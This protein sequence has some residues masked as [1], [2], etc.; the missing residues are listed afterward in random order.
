MVDMPTDRSPLGAFLRSRRDRLTPAQAGIT[1]FPGPRRVPGLR[2]EELAIL[3]GIIVLV[4]L[5]TQVFGGGGGGTPAPKTNKVVPPT[6]TQTT[7]DS[8]N[9]DRAATTVAVLNGTTFA[10]LASGV[11]DKISQGGFT[12][13]DV[14]N[15]IDNTRA[16][17]IVEYTEGNRPA[18]LEVAEQLASERVAREDAKT[19][20]VG[21]D[22]VQAVSAGTRAL[23]P[24]AQVIVTV[25]SDQTPSTG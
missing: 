9:V 17:T 7:A 2:K 5:V 20:D 6:N 21:A 25:G 23:A 24:T 4:I 10:G 1:A 14:R 16:A 19:I 12:R 15:A 13:G 18:A 3:A 22:A 8:E 11:A